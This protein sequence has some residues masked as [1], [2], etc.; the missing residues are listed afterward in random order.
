MWKLTPKVFLFDIHVIYEKMR[1]LRTN[2]CVFICVV[3][4]VFIPWIIVKVDDLMKK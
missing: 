1:S 4:F 2:S 3:N